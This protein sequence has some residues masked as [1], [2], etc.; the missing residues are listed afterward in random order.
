MHDP[1][2]LPAS[3]SG[4]LERLERDLAR[5]EQLGSARFRTIEEELDGWRDLAR[6][7]EDFW[8][9]IDDY[10]NELGIRDRIARYL[11]RSGG[12]LRAWLVRQV[13]EIDETFRANTFLDTSDLMWGGVDDPDQ[14]WSRRVPK[15][16]S[17]ANQVRKIGPEMR[18]HRNRQRD[19]SGQE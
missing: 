5:D 1:S 7:V 4:D 18:A 9:T 3:L 2:S 14:W 8:G 17:L 16:A 6:D 11:R 19:E 15:D 10:I 12:H 13:D